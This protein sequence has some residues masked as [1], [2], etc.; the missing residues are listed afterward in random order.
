MTTMTENNNNN[1][2]KTKSGNDDNDGDPPPPPPPSFFTIDKEKELIQKTKDE[3][4]RLKELA[5]ANEEKSNQARVD[6]QAKIY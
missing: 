1:N 6:I 4:T 5:D 3:E 2:N